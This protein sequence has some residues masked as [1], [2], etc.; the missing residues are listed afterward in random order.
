[1]RRL[2]RNSA[3]LAK[4]Q[5]DDA[6]IVDD[7][8]CTEPKTSAM[9]AML[10]ALGATTGSLIATAEHDRNAHLSFRNIPN[11]DVRPVGDLNAHDV[12]LRRKLIFTKPA[13][14]RLLQGLSAGEASTPES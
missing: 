13:F 8:K 2:A 7:L 4:I 9:A 11:L 14:D 12:L 10:T 3:I 5:A 6:L 1:M